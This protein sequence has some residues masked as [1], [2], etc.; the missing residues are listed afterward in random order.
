[1]ADYRLAHR[2]GLVA[3]RLHELRTLRRRT[4]WWFAAGL[5]GLLLLAVMWW[6]PVPGASAP[7][8]AA[9]GLL[10]LVTTGWFARRPCPTLHE[11]AVEIERRWPSL[12]SRLVTAVDQ[13][14]NETEGGFRFLQHEV[15]SEALLHA[16]RHDWR[17]AVPTTTLARARLL[18][19]AALCAFIAA[20]GGA[21]WR[22]HS[23]SLPM[24]KSGTANASGERT[25]YAV[26]VEPGDAE[27]ERGTSLLVI[28][29]F[30]GRL[31]AEVLLHAT[32]AS[33]TTISQPLS[34]S[35]D[36]PLF[37]GRIA[38]VQTD[39]SYHVTCDGEPSDA[40]RVR[41]FDYPRLEQADARIVHPEY[42][43]LGDKTIVDVRRVSVV[44]GSQLTVVCRLNKPVAEAVLK[45]DDGM[46]LPLTA[47]EDDPAVWSVTDTP[48][49]KREYTLILVDAEGRSN[50]HP[51]EF[52]IDVIPNSPP[53]LA[54]T[55][56][57]RDA[58][59]SP[60][61]EVSLEAR[62]QDDFGLQEYG[63]IYQLPDRDEQSLKLGDAAG[64]NAK[65]QL[66]HQLV[67]EDVGAQPNEL[68]SYYFYADDIGPDGGRR[69]TFSDMYFAEVRH[70]DEE[71]RQTDSQQ[72]PPGQTSSGTPSDELLQ[73]QRDIVS[74]LWNL[75]RRERGEEPSAEF[76]ED[77][78]TIAESQQQAIDM[79]RLLQSRLEDRLAQGHLQEALARMEAAESSLTGAADAVSAGP[80]PQARKEAYAAFQALVRLNVR[81]HLVQQSQSQSGGQ[82]GTSSRSMDR[83][84][85]QLEL[86]NS[87]NR[88]ET[89]RQE[90]PAGDREQL[91][92]LNRLRELARRQSGLNEKIR[93]LETALREARTQPERDE[94]ERQL[95]RLQEEQQ[96]LLRDLDELNE[97]LNNE[98][99]RSR[100]ADV[101]EQAQD[102]REHL[103]QSSE[104]LRNGQTSQA[105]AAGAR[106]ERE[107][108]QLK[109]ELRERTAGE[110]TETLR[111]LGQQARELA[112]REQQIARE[113]GGEA[114]AERRG[115]PQ[116]R[117]E[118]T[119][120]LSEKL[121]DQ[122]ERVGDLMDRLKDVIEAAEPAEP[123]LSKTL[124]EAVRDTRADRPVESLEMAGQFLRHGLKR[125]AALAEAQARA[126]IDKLREGIEEAAESVLGNEVEALRRAQREVDE[127]SR[128]IGSELAQADSQSAAQE[129]RE[130]GSAADPESDRQQPSASRDRAN[131]RSSGRSPGDEP[132]A[133]RGERSD[134]HSGRRGEGG[135][136]TTS[137]QSPADPS[138][139]DQPPAERPAPGGPT[140]AEE[141]A[142]PAGAPASS[143]GDDERPGE[144]GALSSFLPAES[145]EDGGGSGPGGIA[146]PLTGG[147]FM[148]WSDRMR[149]V[150]EMV[151]DPDLR[152]RVAQIR[153]RARQVRIDLR[154]RHSSA[155]NWDLVRTEIYGPMLQLRDRLAEEIARRA[156]TDQIVPLDRDPVPDRYAE[157]VEHY[158]ERLGSGR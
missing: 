157:L 94:L 141:T 64:G 7:L 101:R 74:A 134:D 46:E 138:R 5:S 114:L 80:L 6:A 151:D 153:D 12:D 113:L 23:R 150:E 70:F 33:G 53:E 147:D 79:G 77:V 127:L 110:F 148:R 28:A 97:R 103:V 14:P 72:G 117:D 104:A 57:G 59:V 43:G 41:V 4:R 10:V 19:L 140:N 131:G 9:V 83:Q 35:L 121:E 22:A 100:M 2:V 63:L 40:Y 106:A 54:V 78:Q 88:Y 39:L 49:E 158:Y 48:R 32:D 93:E 123:L 50:R 107:L 130:S 115:P 155:P 129:S 99:N 116:L 42:T 52:I 82:S 125:E 56:P 18:Q 119:D 81:E 76:P 71:F 38:S 152:A 90:Q 61:E 13:R 89:E 31:P 11:A 87:R 45:S 95:R 69:R 17:D 58:R 142:D 21:T 51:P 128:A 124:Y 24:G 126:G 3:D 15:I 55:F 44:E 30:S 20:F 132:G 84:L 154:E 25:P 73:V 120:A 137:N 98:Q 136:G 86:D 112:D 34:R 96:Q 60:L 16:H 8:V 102:V 144:R 1:M 135:V 85:Q 145:F 67:M 118:G 156:S 108:N 109:D 92:I 139:S 143:R 62:A 66:A 37:G 133:E 122:Q 91:Q 47:A 36:D 146:R 65:V 29:R 68:V 27:I 26:V 105:L 111:E 75:I 149:D